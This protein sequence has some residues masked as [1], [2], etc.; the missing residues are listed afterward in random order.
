M[1][2]FSMVVYKNGKRD[3]DFPSFVGGSHW[4]TFQ[5]SFCILRLLYQRVDSHQKML[6]DIFFVPSQAITEMGS[7]LSCGFSFTAKGVQ[8]GPGW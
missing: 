2:G 7:G 1:Y 5:S 6:Q 8:R 4:L 3:A